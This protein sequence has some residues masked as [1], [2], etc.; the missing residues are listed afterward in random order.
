MLVQKGDY[1]QAMPLLEGF[2]T[3][4]DAEMRKHRGEAQYFLGLA[5]FQAGQYQEAADQ[6]DAALKDENPSYGADASYMRFKA[7]RGGDREE[8]QRRGDGAVR[9]RHSRL[10]DRATRITSPPSK[11]S[12]VS[13]SCCKRSTSSPTPCRRMPR[14]AAIP[15]SSCAR[16]SRPCNATSSCCKPPIRARHA[17]RAGQE[18]R[19]RACRTSTSKRPT[20]R[21]ASQRAISCRSMRCTPRSR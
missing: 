13:A 18:H 10:P 6:L 14:S 21:S 2:V 9:A 1:K 19:R 20:T 17:R 5:K 12:S 7:T 8:P 4:T 15:A 16:S 3:S 11:R